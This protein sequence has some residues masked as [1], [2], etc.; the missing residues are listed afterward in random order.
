MFFF[1]KDSLV[2]KG[3][4]AQDIIH[5][6]LV[7]KTDLVIL[8]PSKNFQLGEIKRNHSEILGFKLKNSY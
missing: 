1:I 5:M 2:T 4:L 6:E 8:T 3:S 7:K